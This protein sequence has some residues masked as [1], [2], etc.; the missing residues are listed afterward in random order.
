MTCTCRFKG[1]VAEATKQ[2]YPGCPRWHATFHEETVDKAFGEQDSLV[3][4]TADADSEISKLCPR[5]GYVIGGLVDR[6]RHKR[7]CLEKAASL[8][9]NVARLPISEHLK[10]AGSKVCL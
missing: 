8:G 2:Q 7:L 10:L 9:L 4:L 3:Y 6:N 1:P 5:K